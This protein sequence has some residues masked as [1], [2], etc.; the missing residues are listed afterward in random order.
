MK[1]TDVS[2]ARVAMPL[3]KPLGVGGWW[4]RVREFVLVW[5]ET[6]EGLTGIGVTQGG[7]F[8]GQGRLVDVALEEYLKPLL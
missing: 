4:N 3:E 1:I 7:Y 8:P 2:F 5:I 6:D